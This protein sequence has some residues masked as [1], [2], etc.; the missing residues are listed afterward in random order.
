M[1][2][3]IGSDHAGFELKEKVKQPPDQP[4]QD[5]NDVGTVSTESVITLISRTWLRMKL[6]TSA[7]TTAFLV[8]GSGI[9]HGNYREQG[10][11]HPRR[12]R[13]HRD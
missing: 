11:G 1:K 3:A 8:C 2:I 6:P 4:G 10:R 9:G 7:P 5:V 13:Q 12:Q